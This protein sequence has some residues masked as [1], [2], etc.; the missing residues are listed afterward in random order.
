MEIEKLQ[1]FIDNKKSI[2]HI[3]EETGKSYTSVRYWIKKHNLETS[4]SKRAKNPKAEPEGEK[5]C[6]RCNETKS[7]ED[8][9]RRRQGR[10]CSPYCKPCTTDETIE[11]Q[12]N[13]K[14]ECVDYKGG[15]CE[16]CGYKKCNSALEFHHLDPS[17]KDFSISRA[18][19][20]T[21]GK[22]VKAEL[23]KC[24]IVCANCHREIH[25]GVIIL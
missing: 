25:E 4:Y 3:S 10:E 19:L 17:K 9:Y 6:N 15:E 5:H 12:R 11:R 8:F 13:F 21:F 16:C 22:K 18:R 7:V 14:Q 2:R 20:T 1:L 24:M 23:D